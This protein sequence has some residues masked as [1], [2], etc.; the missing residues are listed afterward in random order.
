MR[1]TCPH[2]GFAKQIAADKIPANVV[3]V[4]CP[5]CKQPFPLTREETLESAPTIEESGTD[6]VESSSPVDD[7][8]METEPTPDGMDNSAETEAETVPN[9]S[10]SDETELGPLPEPVQSEPACGEHVEAAGIGARY[11]ALLIDSMLILFMVLIL[12]AG[13]ALLGNGIQTEGQ[14]LLGLTFM[15]FALTLGF[16]YHTLFIGACGQTPGKRLLRIRVIQTDQSEMTYRRAMLREVFGKTLSTPLLLGYLMALFHP[17][18]LAAHD[19]I[20]DTCVVKFTIESPSDR[21]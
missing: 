10:V 20:A 19:K 3:R 17:E 11:A 8:A 9:V 2:C 18:R 4:T 6:T 12:Q 7:G 5:D 1:I 21:I 15:L 16:A 13:L 14:I